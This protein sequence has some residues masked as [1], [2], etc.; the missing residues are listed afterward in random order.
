MQPCQTTG[1][2]TG[3]R[4]T[5]INGK[6]IVI[7]STVQLGAANTNSEQNKNLLGALSFY[8]SNVNKKPVSDA[9][10]PT[11]HVAMVDTG[12]N[13]LYPEHGTSE[14]W[15]TTEAVTYKRHLDWHI[16]QSDSY[17]FAVH[18]FNDDNVEL[19][20]TTQTLYTDILNTAVSEG[21]SQLVRM[22]NYLP[23]INKD[24]AHEQERYRT[25]CFGRANA[26]EKKYQGQQL[27][28]PAAS[29]VGTLAKPASI[30]LLACNDAHKAVHIEN[31]AQTP[32]YA[33]PKQYGPRSP[34]FARATCLLD[35]N[36][37][38]V[39]LFVSGTAAI[40]QS[41]SLYA[42]DTLA[43]LQ[44]T[45]ENISELISRSN[46]SQYGIESALGIGSLDSIKVYYRHSEELSDIQTVCEATFQSHQPIA[47]LHADICRAD[48][49]IEIEG[50]IYIRAAK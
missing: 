5:R 37:N 31:P 35:C 22:W 6:S 29:G 18:N 36:H 49:S 30:A 48:L 13:H 34:S 43:Q 40:K 38:P 41:E 45:L 33:Y 23:D 39:M 19:A 2:T 4:P 16:A 11:A 20:R 3:N 14:L 44:C 9:C 21:F 32:A 15:S 26:F 27:K 1:K 42:N 17:F 50:I 10:V 25:F 47:Y 8:D 28:M 46:L 7:F 12:L 24:D